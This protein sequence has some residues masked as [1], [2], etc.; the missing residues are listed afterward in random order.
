MSQSAA[1][2]AAVEGCDGFDGPALSEGATRVGAV[3]SAGLG[4]DLRQL[5]FSP[6][7]WLKKKKKRE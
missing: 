5:V 2:A 7:V 6:G 1:A 3:T 4:G